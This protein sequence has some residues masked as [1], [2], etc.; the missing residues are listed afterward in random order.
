MEMPAAIRSAIERE[1]EQYT[2]KQLAE[3]AKLI[4]ERYRGERSAKA[5]VTR[6]VEAMAYAASRM[7]ATYGA[8]YTALRLSNLPQQPRTLLDVGAG[9]GA[10]AMAAAELYSLS[11][12]F[13]LE[14]EPAMRELGKKLAAASEQPA[15]RGAEFLPC[16]IAR[17]TGGKHADLVLAGYM[18]NEL[19]EKDRAAALE[20]LWNAAVQT[21][22]LVEPGTP[23]GFA[24]LMQARRRLLKMGARI[25]APCAHENE[26]PLGREDW[27]NFTCR[28]ARTRLHR[29]LKGGDVPYEDEKF[30]FLTATR[31][32]PQRADNRVLRH[33][34]IAPG[35]IRLR[36]CGA[37][38]VKDVTVTKKDGQLFKKARKANCGDELEASLFA[39]ETKGE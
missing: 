31:R 13:C 4:S 15:V 22:V 35:N 18:L 17:G 7:P 29:S 20:E 16:D 25:A 2:S 3:A 12:I 36:L 30:I 34:Q 27:C 14:R 10:G 32:E 6:G 39:P 19:S 9:T 33:P 24:I 5:M 28:I 11:K 21:L 37:E 1:A 38:G 26:C 23:E 8:L